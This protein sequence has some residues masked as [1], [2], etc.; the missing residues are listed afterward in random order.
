MKMGDFKNV[1]LKT[2]FKIIVSVGL[3]LFLLFKVNLKEVVNLFL[4]IPFSVLAILFLLT[5]IIFLIKAIK[6]GIL[7][8]S[9]NIN[10]KLIEI[11]KVVLIGIFYGMITPAKIGDFLKCYHI[12]YSKSDVIPTILW[13]RIIDI[14]VLILLSIL[15]VFLFFR[16]WTIIHVVLLLT[17]TFVSIILLITN[18]KTIAFFTNILKIPEGTRKKFIDNMI[19]IRGNKKA[20][21][22]VFAW[23]LCFY[24]ILMIISICIL[25]S[26]D[27]RMELSIVFFVPVIILVANIPVTISGLGLREYAAIL[28]FTTVNQPAAIGFAFSLTLFTIT[29]LFPGIIGYILHLNYEN[30]KD[31]NTR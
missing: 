7:L 13:D 25:R 5:F 20:I 31:L 24:I 26:F 4:T 17:V 9:I 29:S 15:S 21:L 1:K 30:I 12:D 27:P 6:W 11:F 23:T 10:I 22:M 14:A 28:C 18:Q 2:I 16:D 19:E 3:L 8:R